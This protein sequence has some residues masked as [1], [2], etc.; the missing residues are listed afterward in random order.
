VTAV[1]YAQEDFYVPV[2]TSVK[3]CNVFPGGKMSLC[4]IEHTILE[5]LGNM[6]NSTQT[7]SLD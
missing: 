7:V 1:A 4:G 3:T 5:R 2:K 6:Y